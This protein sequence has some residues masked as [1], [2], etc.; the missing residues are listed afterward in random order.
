MRTELRLLAIT[1]L[2][3]AALLTTACG[4]G[5]R[6]FKI[7]IV[8]DCE[9][10]L[11]PLSDEMLAGAQLP[12]L[13][14]G[15]KLRGSGPSAGIA[16]P[17]VG[18]RRVEIRRGC[19]EITYLTQ[20]IENVRRLVEADGVDV[21]VAPMF[22]NAEGVVLRELAH[23]YPHTAFVVAN[24]GA[25]ETTLRDAAPNLYRFF[26]DA[27]Q[28]SAGLGTF[29]YR[30][31]GW[32]HAAVV[33]SD[34]G[35]TWPQAAG[36]VAEFC[37]LGG[38]VQRVPAMDGASAATVE[39]L[40][41]HTDGVALLTGSFSDTVGFAAAYARSRPALARHLILGPGALGFFD[42]VA[43][44]K[45]APLLSGVVLD[46]LS[47]DP[48]GRAWVRFR[49][50]FEQHFPWHRSPAVPA[51]FPIVLAYYDAVEAT[52]RAL[53]RAGG[54]GAPFARALAAT[55]LDSPGGPIRLDR[56]RQAIVSTYLSQVQAGRTRPSIRTFR[57]VPN[58]E[59]TFA[60]YFGP[61]TLSPTASRP[62]CHRATPPSWA[63]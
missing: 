23:R 5:E 11:S 45:S 2:A 28:A 15:G 4:G 35:F 56:R 12:L 21:V 8:V 53:E 13:D 58:V 25:P 48:R 59:Q 52:L 54:G 43:F 62:S 19:A 57:A 51:D 55:R 46:G 39:R 31:L 33:F 10:T 30:D 40:A 37:A 63:K 3:A 42:P 34:N 29:A 20:L 38:S 1:G 32:R 50:A 6:A 9:G 16:G 24:S 61:T 44:R 7:G 41:K 47:Y 60:G 17:R 14:R 36:F 49:R 18:G 27:A 26:P 22:G